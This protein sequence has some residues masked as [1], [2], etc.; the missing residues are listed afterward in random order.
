[1][2]K[3]QVTLLV[4]ALLIALAYTS[5]AKKHDSGSKTYDKQGTLYFLPTHYTYTQ[6][7]DSVGRHYDWAC[8]AT[9]GKLSCTDNP[10]PALM[11]V[12]LTADGPLFFAMRFIDKE[13]EVYGVD[14]LASQSNG[15]RFNYRDF[16]TTADG[17][18]VICLPYTTTDKK[19]KE[20]PEESCYRVDI[21]N[22]HPT[23]P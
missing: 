22:P 16:T 19:G 10:V 5:S 14:V 12:R 2:K 23:Q 21:K 6:Q 4:A 15:S 7:L 13:H 3:T 20:K 1:M 8:D 11:Y 9:A 17:L 18:R